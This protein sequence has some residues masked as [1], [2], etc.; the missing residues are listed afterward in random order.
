MRK[1]TIFFQF[2]KNEFFTT[3]Y[4]KGYFEYERDGFGLVVDSLSPLFEELDKLFSVDFICDNKYIK[5][6][7]AF[8]ETSD[9]KNCQ[10]IFN[11]INN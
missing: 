11:A 7:D 10:R 4:A 8:F 3:H 9:N 1:P 2:D 6:I 5:R